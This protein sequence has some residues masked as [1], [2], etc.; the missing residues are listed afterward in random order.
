M[1]AQR[2]ASVVMA[3]QPATRLQA[4][5]GGRLLPSCSKGRSPLDGIPWP[6]SAGL[7]IPR[8]CAIL[9]CGDFPFVQ[10][11]MPSLSTLKPPKQEI[12]VLA[13]TPVLES[14]GVQ[15]FEGEV[16]RLNLLECEVIERE[17]C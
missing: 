12:G 13:A 17:G 2:G 16:Q 1:V 10:M 5:H 6:G 9:G 8:E 7:I 3:E 4:Q 15:G 11:L 14:L